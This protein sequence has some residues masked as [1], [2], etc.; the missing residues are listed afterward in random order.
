MIGNAPGSLAALT[1]F[2]GRRDVEPRV[3][4]M[5][6]ANYVDLG[7]G[8]RVGSG[9]IV[10]KWSLTVSSE[11]YWAQLAAFFGTIQ[12][13]YT[14]KNDGTWGTFVAAIVG[15]DQEPEHF[16][17]RVLECEITLR[18]LQEQ[19]GGN[20]QPVTLSAIAPQVTVTNT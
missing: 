17:G 11:A 14:R 8:S 19:V 3:L 12:Y 13:V 9:W 2:G 5:Q 4:P 16:A 18:L 1:T 7:N 20:L 15:P 6:Y 10:Q